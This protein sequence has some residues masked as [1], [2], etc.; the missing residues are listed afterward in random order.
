MSVCLFQSEQKAYHVTLLSPLYWIWTKYDIS[1]GKKSNR[2]ILKNI[3]FFSD[4][5]KNVKKEDTFLLGPFKR[6]REKVSLRGQRTMERAFW[7][8][9][10]NAIYFIVLTFQGSKKS[11]FNTCLI[12]IVNEG[13]AN[14]GQ[15]VK[16]NLLSTF[17]WPRDS[18][19]L[20]H[21]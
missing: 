12:H 19:W 4:L 5:K 9:E 20:L 17:V 6:N 2:G 10:T 3:C 15:W 11:V 14:Y 16:P 18:E 7:A 1:L 8:Q 21:F 13:L